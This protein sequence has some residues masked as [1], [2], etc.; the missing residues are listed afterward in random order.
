MAGHIDCGQERKMRTSKKTF[1][2][3]V[4]I[5]AVGIAWLLNVTEFLDTVDWSWPVLLAAG[6]ILAVVCGGIDKLTFVLAPFL[7]ISSLFAVLRQVGR[8][9]VNF[10]I[11]CLFIILGI[12]W[13]IAELLN[14]PTPEWLKKEKEKE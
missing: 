7:L 6:A 5:I 8:L 14:L 11:P 9:T 12:L 1:I 4:L 3:P 2:A 10:E 13:L